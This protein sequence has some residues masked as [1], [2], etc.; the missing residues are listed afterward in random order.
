[1]R[2]GRR[3][4]RERALR[5]HLG[6]VAG[7]AV[8]DSIPKDLTVIGPFEFLAGVHLVEI[9]DSETSD[10]RRDI[11]GGTLAGRAV[12]GGVDPIIGAV[13]DVGGPLL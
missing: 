6:G 13:G 10:F 9:H 5:T 4:E 2:K 1:M 3:E 12:A 11:H 7:V 8:I